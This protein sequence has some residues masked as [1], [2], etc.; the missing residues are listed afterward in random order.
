MAAEGGGLFHRTMTRIAFFTG[1]AT[2]C[3]A[4]ANP[5]E[6]NVYDVF[7]T[8]RSKHAFIN[9]YR[10]KESEKWKFESKWKDLARY[11]QQQEG[12]LYNKLIRSKNPDDGE[13][14]HYYGVMQ[15][16]TGEAFV[17]STGK[18]SYMQLVA[19]LPTAERSKPLMYKVVVDDTEFDPEESFAPYNAQK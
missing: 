3:Y 11:Y 13:T 17:K 12:Y 6:G 16:T 5:D 2:V 7:P 14:Y 4:F 10:V 1:G 8:S 9:T 19:E 15:W 18:P